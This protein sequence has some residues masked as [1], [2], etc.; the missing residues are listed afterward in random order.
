[1]RDFVFN[2]WPSLTSAEQI[3]SCHRMATEAWHAATAADGEHS[4]RLTRFARAWLELAKEIADASLGPFIS[5]PIGLGRG[6]VPVNFRR[7]VPMRA[8][9]KAREW[10]MSSQFARR[11]KP[12]KR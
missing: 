12:I 10:P 3:A 7:K 11:L 2:D 8:T 6:T 9:A 1:M 4:K 5:V